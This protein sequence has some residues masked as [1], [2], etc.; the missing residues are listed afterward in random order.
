MKF[1]VSLF[2][3]VLFYNFSIAQKV[4]YATMV[5][6]E[7]VGGSSNTVIL[8][9]E[10]NVNISSQRSYTV[11]KFK[12]IRVYNKLG[13]N[14]IDAI[15]HYDKS[16]VI[17]SI[18]ARIFN[19]FGKQIKV[20]RHADFLDQSVAD[21]FSILTDNRTLSLNYVPTEYPFT[22]VYQSEVRSD[23]TAFLPRWF[24][25]DDP[26]ESVLKSSL[27]LK[28]PENL[29]FK[30]K[31]VNFEDYPNI[32]KIQNGNIISFM[33]E[34]L[35]SVKME[36]F[37][38]SFQNIIPHVLFG[39]EK[40]SLEGVDGE[41]KTW[42]EFGSWVNEKLLAKTDELSPET[43]EKI[44]ALVGKET[45][46]VK[47]AKIVYQ[48]VQD[49]TR[50]VSI[51]LGIGGWKPMLAK[52]VDRLGYG[53][54]KALSN[55]TR[56]LLEIVNV[57]SYYT[58]IYAGS[59]K[60]NIDKDFVS[61]Q[62]NHAILTL[63][64]GDKLCFLECTSQTI[65]FGFEGDFTDDRLALIIKPDGGEIV[66]TSDYNEKLNSQVTKASYSIDDE[67]TISSTISIK[68]KGVQYDNRTFLEKESP[69]K[70]MEYYKSYLKSIPNLKLEKTACN[71]NKEAMEC[72]E[73]LQISAKNYG[74]F[75]GVSLM[76]PVNAFNQLSSIPQR[77]KVRNNSFEIDRGFY[78][79]DEFEISIPENYVVEAK[80]DNFILKDKFGEYRIEITTINSQK[81]LY[82]RSLLINKGLY[83]KSEYD[84]FRKFREQIA[85]ADNSKMIITKKT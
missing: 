5:V 75:S 80:P 69:E 38:P 50:Y 14:N 68:T 74:S 58:I 51:Q 42:K 10:I 48:Y 33:A 85:R 11:K 37:A 43:Q 60:Q 4:D 81:L 34:N 21:G 83:G 61:M 15:E 8:N 76:F 47:K 36:E 9:Q 65:A 45:D 73:N 49:K 23:N 82:K 25:I 7:S 30:Y 31:E 19:A 57:P 1:K 2:L 41:A 22:I 28:Y 20:I 72:I 44:K 24:P 52:D 18:E 46:P 78:D 56:S 40:F 84:N 13:L 55:Y 63:P 39:L 66:R 12:A 27:T 26:Y 70:R 17:L 62:G 64:V 16:N 3:V 67:G 71:N 54:C 77:Y 35:P 6:P 32:I 79:E 53:D 29:G 59:Q